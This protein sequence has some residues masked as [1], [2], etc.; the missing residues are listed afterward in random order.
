MA[1]ER[2]AFGLW[3]S[4]ITPASLAR[5][6]RLS[7]PSW[8]SDGRTLAWL[9]GRSNAGV[10]VILRDGEMAAHEFA[11]GM[12]VR[13]L[14]G[15]GGGDLALARGDLWFVGQKDQ[16]IYRQALEGGQPRPITP[17]FG[18]ASSP[19]LSPNGRWLVYVHTFEDEDCLAVVDAEGKSWP[20]KLASGRDFYMQPAWAP[21][22]SRLT[23]IEWDHPNMPWDGTEL[24]VADLAFPE[25]SPPRIASGSISGQA[26]RSE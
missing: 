10:P 22:G 17:P 6:T 16:R 11:D 8:D 18:A 25:G 19:A 7:T 15:Y 2:R 23:W 20:A 21:S 4:P 1:A 3:D 5:G 26:Q 24:K 9:E 12:S 14:V 13:A